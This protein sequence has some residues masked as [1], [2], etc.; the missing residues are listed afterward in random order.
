MLELLDSSKRYKEICQ[1]RHLEAIAVRGTSTARILCINPSWETTRSLTNIKQPSVTGIKPVSSARFPRMLY[2]STINR[3]TKRSLERN[4]LCL[5]GLAANTR[6]TNIN[7]FYQYVT[8]NRIKEIC[9]RR[10]YPF[11]LYLNRI[12]FL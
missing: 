9:L 7:S 1:I 3:Q 11:A 5:D 2:I 12:F 8:L 6:I 10:I 4:V